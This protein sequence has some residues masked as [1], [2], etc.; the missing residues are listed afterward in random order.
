MSFLLVAVL[1]SATSV[2]SYASTTKMTSSQPINGVVMKGAFVNMKQHDN[3]SPEAPQDYI[4]DSLKMISKAGLDHAR[5]LFYWEAFERDPKAFMKEIES[6]AKAG[7]KYGVKI[8]YDNHQWHTS[9]WL[10][11]KGTG[12]PWSLFEDSKYSK[13][14]G[15][16]TPDKGAQVFW[17]DWWDRSVKDNDGKDGWTLMAEYLKKIVLAV[18]NHSSTLGYEIL[19]EPHVDNTDQWS[20][21][22]KFNSFITEELRDITSKT[23]VYSMNVP[24]DLKS[25]INIS[26]ENL[27]KMAPSSKQNIAFKIS[28]YGVPDRDDYQKERFDLFL[29]TRD[30]TGVPLY[31]GEWNNVVRTKEG[32][33]F[34]INPGASDFTNSNAGK[35]LE[36]FKKEGIWGTA[37]WKWDYR[38]ADTASFNLVNDEGGKLVPTKYFGILEDTVEKVYG[39]FDSVSTSDVSASGNTSTGGDDDTST[40]D[41]S[42][43]GNT[44]TSDDDTSTSDV[45]ASGNISTPDDGKETNLINKLVKTGKFTEAEAKQFVSKS[46]QNGPDVTSTSDNTQSSNTQSSNNQTNSN[47]QP[48]KA[49]TN[50]PEKYDNFDDL[51]DDIKNHVVDIEDISLNAFQ[52]SGAYQGADQETQ[53]CIDLAAKIGDNLGDQEIVNCSEDPNFYR[54][55]IS[56]TGSNDDNNSDNNGN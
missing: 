29:D 31:I 27:A 30:L 2:G 1:I 28:V 19:S 56:S 46:M 16:N 38:D 36:A 22:G 55:E 50:N 6:V 26:P 8:I 43:S 32:G 41:V 20:K 37:F 10:E 39:S 25:N 17:K 24:V 44:S 13:G 33:V 9:S 35:I 3:G 47:D 4:D 52:D 18:D 14:G 11:D 15:G 5:F 48:S 7:D 42:A 54:N 45:S 49:N 51:V 40:S 34:K 21:I 12:F 23:I 53:D